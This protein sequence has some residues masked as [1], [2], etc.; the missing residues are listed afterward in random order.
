MVTRWNPSQPFTRHHRVS[1]VRR[2]HWLDQFGDPLQPADPIGYFM[3]LGLCHRREF[4]DAMRSPA[5]TFVSKLH[6]LDAR[7]VGKALTM[8]RFND[9]FGADHQ[10]WALD[11][12]KALEGE[13][14]LFGAG[15]YKL[16]EK[17]ETMPSNTFHLQY[18]TCEEQRK[19]MR[20]MGFPGCAPLIGRDGV[21]PELSKELM[22]HIGSTSVIKLDDKGRPHSMRYGN[23]VTWG[24]LY[25]LGL[26]QGYTAMDVFATGCRMEHM[27][28]KRDNSWNSPEK[29]MSKKI[30]RPAKHHAHQGTASKAKAKARPWVD[31]YQ[32]PWQCQQSWH[33][34]PDMRPGRW[35]CAEPRGHWHGDVHQEWDRKWE[36]QPWA[37]Y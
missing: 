27:L 35:H 20:K 10:R 1:S 5:E 24:Q 18:A 26:E 34:Q 33:H 17:R 7:S 37:W 13:L 3:D 21:P 16:P 2:D 19:E 32:S 23:V 31:P 8:E 12:L 25:L 9:E 22:A 15:W 14:L 29:R 30:S 6:E 4:I 11:T 28:A 36:S